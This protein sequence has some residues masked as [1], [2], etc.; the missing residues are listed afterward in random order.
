[1]KTVSVG[2]PVFNGQRFLRA[3]LDSL[4]AQEYGD[5]EF[6][7]SDNA[8]TDETPAIVQEYAARD[9]RIRFE[10]AAEN[11]GAA[12]NHRRVLEL[13]RST[14]FKWCG[15]DDLVHPRF[16]TACVA[17]LDRNPDAILAYP[18]TIVIDEA[19]ATV[20]RTIERLAVDSPDAVE[21]FASLMSAYSV[22]H[23]PYYGLMRREHMLRARPLGEFLGHDRCFL[24]QLAL[25]GPFVEIPEYLMY[26]RQHVGN[27]R[28]QTEEQRFHR[29]AEPHKY[30]PREWRVLW[31]HVVAIARAPLWLPTKARLLARLAR[32]VVRQRT[33]LASEAKALL[34]RVA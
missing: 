10:R 3:C 32:W 6:I 1:V 26:R 22:T 33:D 11:R 19:G 15:A 28:D 24:G 17:A 34:R 21:R 8:S 23:N 4:L 5:F 13:S 27:N 2:L 30:R 9:R 25:L 14:Y 16:L 12:W 20:G 31:E 7:V 18:K 29:P